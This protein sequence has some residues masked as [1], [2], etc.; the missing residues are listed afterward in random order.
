MTLRIGCVLV[1][2]LS[3]VL[4]MAAQTSGSSPA[5]AQVPPLI[6]FSSVAADEGDNSLSGVVSITFSLYSGQQGGAPLWTE[7]QQNIQLDPTG[8]YSVQLGVTKPAGVPTQLF[9][10]GEARWLGVRIAEQ[11]E[12]PRVLLLSVPYALKAGDAATIGGLPPSAF[13]LAAP[14]NGTTSVSTLEPTTG[15]GAP[16]PSGNVTGTGTVNYLPLWDSTSDIISSVLFQK[17]TGST[18]KIGIGTTKPAS[19][20]DVK[21]GSTIRGLFSLPAAGT[22][23]ASA[24]FNSQPMNLAA[25]VFNSSTSTA[26]PQTFQWEAEPVGNDTSNATGSLNLLFAQGTGKQA[27]TGLNIASNG[28]ITFAKGQTFPGT[29]GGTVTSVGSGPGL[30][31]GP[32]TTTGT[33]S[34]AAG[35]VINAMLANPA[36][37]VAA[38]TDLTGGGLVALGG[39]TTLNLDTTQVPLLNTANSFTGN[40]SIT[41]NLAATGSIS[42]GAGT[43]TGLVTE[44]GALLPASGTATTGQGYNSQPL[45]SVTS[46]Y[47]SGTASAQNQ[48]FQW[49][50][51]PVGNNT[52]SPSGKLD[53]LFGANGA[54]PTETGLSVAS[55]GQITFATG[56]TFPGNGTVTSVGSGP[57]LTGGPITTSGTLSIATGGVSNAMLVNPSLTVLAGTDLT[58]GGAVALG[59]STTLNLDT[60]R[61]P[62]L[63]G[64]NFFS[65]N[66]TVDGNLSALAVSGSSFWIGSTPFAFGSYVYLNAFLGFAGNSTMTGSVNTA[67]GPYALSSNTTGSNNTASGYGALLSNTTGSNNTASGSQALYCNSGSNNTASG[68]LAL[69]CNYSGSN[70]TASGYQALWGNTSGSY[71][72]ASGTDALYTNDGSYNTATG[73]QALYNNS[74]GSSNTADGM[75]ALYTNSSGYNNTAAGY[76]ALFSNTTGYE[77][78]AVGVNSADNETNSHGLACVGYDTCGGTHNLHNAGAFGTR[79]TVEVSDAIVLGSVAGVNGAT[80]T[81]RI[82]IGTTKPTNLLTLGQ[83]AGL[84]ISDGWATYSSRRWKTNIQPLHNAL[85][86]VEQLRGVSY[87]LKDSGKHEIGVIAEDVGKVVPEVVSYEENGKD[88]RGVD[89]SRLTALLIEAV[90]QQQRQIKTQQ[91]QIARLNG[92]VGVLEATLRT[93]QHAGESPATVRSSSTK[94]HGLPS[95]RTKYVGDNAGNGTFSLS[96]LQQLVQK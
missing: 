59:G 85:S 4:P 33:L 38:G 88:A 45:D 50:A 34:I 77:N 18:A 12:Q 82:G 75:Y 42:G 23:T 13:V 70:N 78:T 47:N 22:A 76:H 92:K 5:S 80:A 66:Q 29:G 95:E 10:S 57:G 31:G 86:M 54:T 81:V 61:V 21:G 60:S 30:T 53:L 41:G 15:Q 17:G 48:D 1:G 90:K 25:S 62:Q 43:F 51:E 96:L 16:P 71:N 79:A 56:Q 46:A 3:L 37:T 58:G 87:D 63:S 39:I 27:E 36:L 94:T 26:V 24:G 74:A 83:G 2:F 6:Q 11:A 35:G 9:T 28:Q 7:T 65:G 69:F 19:T 8:H 64:G 20:L 67:S 49:L 32:I 89:Y 91:Q 68:S 52:S 72:T 44:A 73:Y 93:V 14:Q 55:N 40:Q 84:S